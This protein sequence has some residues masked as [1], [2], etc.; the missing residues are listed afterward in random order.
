M[1]FQNNHNTTT[2]PGRLNRSIC[3]KFESLL[4]CI[5]LV[6]FEFVKMF[7]NVKVLG[8]LVVVFLVGDAIGS[9]SVN[10]TLNDPCVKKCHV[11]FDYRPFCGS[12]NYTYPTPSYLSCFK[13]CNISITKAYDGPCKQKLENVT[14]VPAVVAAKASESDKHDSLEEHPC[15]KKCPKTQD[16]RPFCGSDNHT[17]GNKSYLGCFKKCNIS[18]TMAY[19]GP[20]K[21]TPKQ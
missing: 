7:L 8:A 3:F 18:V 11:T 17:Y 13:S 16:L 14:D 2:I 1:H 21:G 20:C 9:E 5:L 15:V 19:D 10:P 6:F 12:D 4:F